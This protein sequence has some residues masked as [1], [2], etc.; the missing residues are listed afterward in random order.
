MSGLQRI[1]KAHGKTTVINSEGKKVIWVW[2]YAQDRARIKAEMTKEEIAANK[3]A[4]AA[5]QNFNL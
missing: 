3:A 4:M 1:L 5:F 2:D